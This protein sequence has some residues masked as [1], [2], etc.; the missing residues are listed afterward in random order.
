MCF[1]FNMPHNSDEIEMT[2]KYEYKYIAIYI[3]NIKP[4]IAY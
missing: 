3:K 1:D 4:T 2:R